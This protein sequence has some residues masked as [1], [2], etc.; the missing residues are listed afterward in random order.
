MTSIKD[1]I[2]TKRGYT[3]KGDQQ[4]QVAEAYLSGR[5][6]FMSAP[7]G[8]GKASH[9]KLLL[10]EYWQRIFL[11]LYLE[12]LLKLFNNLFTVLSYLS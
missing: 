12:E 9:L 10:K 7:A 8:S 5:D 1:A 3:S 2:V 4:R 6:V 11:L